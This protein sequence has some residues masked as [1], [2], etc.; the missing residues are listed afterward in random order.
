MKKIYPILLVVLV[1]FTNV[2]LAGAQTLNAVWA[3]SAGAE[4]NFNKLK[5]GTEGTFYAINMNGN[6]LAKYNASGT[7]LWS[8]SASSGLAV[9]SI[10][11]DASNNVYVTGTFNETLTFGSITLENTA[12][13]VYNTCIVQFNS[14]GEAL[15]AIATGE[16]S[17]DSYAESAIDASGNIYLSGFSDGSIK[18]GSTTLDGVYL[19]K[20]DA[21]GIV[22]WTNTVTSSVYVRGGQV[23]LDDE[24]KPYLGGYF[25]GSITHGES[26]LSSTDGSNFFLAK[27][28]TDGTP[29]WAA[30]CGST[31]SSSDD[32]PNEMVADHNGNIYMAGVYRQGLYGLAKFNKTAKF[33]WDVTGGGGNQA[34]ASDMAIDAEGNLYV[35]GYFYGLHIS[36]GEITLEDQYGLSKDQA[37]VVKYNSDFTALW[38]GAVGA[39]GEDTGERGRAICAVG[40]GVVFAGTFGGETLTLGETTLI[41]SSNGS[42]NE[43]FLAKIGA[44]NTTAIL[45]HAT[46]TNVTAFPNPTQ[47]KIQ[48]NGLPEGTYQVKLNTLS[49]QTIYQSEISDVNA[50]IDIIGQPKGLYIVELTNGK[51]F[52]GT[53]KL[54]VE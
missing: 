35:T 52:S 44:D 24:D 8:K 54:I 25:R 7:E 20:L 43:T 28:N 1:A 2:S 29:A 12:T 38:A 23:V 16:S 40:D 45:S 26:S 34:E 17:A 13:G 14:D 15:S 18:F 11:T 51:D 21:T 31:G 50:S 41:N 30:A 9:K 49:G 42:A 22:Q 33:L 32:A 19:V 46:H 36:F 27:Y 53:G 6:Y 37:F 48:F 47:G 10:A 3:K 5:A 39:V 4:E